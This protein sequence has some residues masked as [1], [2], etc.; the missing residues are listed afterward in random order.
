MKDRSQNKQRKMVSLKKIEHSRRRKIIIDVLIKIR[1]DT[2]LVKQNM[3][4]FL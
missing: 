3:I 1:K 4:L 2:E